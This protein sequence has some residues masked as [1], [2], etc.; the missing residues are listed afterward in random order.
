MGFGFDGLRRV[1]RFIVLLLAWAA[2]LTGCTSTEEKARTAFVQSYTCPGEHVT[3]APIAGVTMRELWL[4]SSESGGPASAEI[5]ADPARLA[6]W[7]REQESKIRAFHIDEYELL[8]AS[9]CG[10]EVDYA[11]YC[12]GFFTD[13]GQNR[14]TP[15]DRCR[16]QTRPEL[17]SR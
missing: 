14:G 8:H 10:H 3:V 2:L 4:H 1:R 9:G 13:M 7:Q 15:Q 17:P 16:C 6:L 5:Q 12:P 11:C